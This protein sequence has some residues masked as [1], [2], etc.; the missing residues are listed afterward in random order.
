MSINPVNNNDVRKI[1]Q[2]GVDAGYFPDNTVVQKATEM[3][4]PLLRGT[5]EVVSVKGENGNYSRDIDHPELDK[6]INGSAEDLERLIAYIL[7]DS[8]EK[9]VEQSKTRL[10]TMLDKMDSEQQEVMRK[11]GKALEETKKQQEAQKTSGILGWILTGL[12]VLACAITIAM[13]AGAAT[14]LAIAGCVLTCASTALTV[15]N[16]ILDATGVKE[17]HC[18]DRAEEMM[19]D[20]PSLTRKEALEK[21]NK[22]W[23]LG[24]GI[25]MGV[26]AAASLGVGIANIVKGGAQ[27]QKL[28][29]ALA[30][31]GKELG[32]LGGK[33]VQLFLKIAQTGTTLAETGVSVGQT[34]LAFKLADLI[35]SQAKAQAE[36]LETKAFL[37]RIKEM[38]E[39]EQDVLA[40]LMSR[41]TDVFAFLGDIIGSQDKSVNRILSEMNPL[42]A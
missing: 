23:D 28:A 6:A 24:W 20:D 42:T 1:L 41:I 13:T 35:K 17:K 25:A 30:K 40:D 10:K 31:E 33:H 32:T 21:A 16:Q 38:V 15:T 12:S 36:L 2:N 14:P 7:L 11:L 39:S 29:E 34:V 9:Q 8:D 37:A 22:E 26:L 19:K 5:V 27:L 4:V 3:V 18:K